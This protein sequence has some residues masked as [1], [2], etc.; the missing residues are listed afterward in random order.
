VTTPDTNAHATHWATFA[1]DD[2]KATPNLTI[3]VGLRWEYHPSFTD[4]FNN[5]AVFLPNTNTVVNGVNVHGSVV[6]PNGFVPY[7]NSV[8]ADSIAPTPI[9]TNT[10]AGLNSTLH[11]NDKTSFAPRVGFAWLPYGNSKTVIR[12][13]YGKYIE[14]I[15][16][17]LASAAW[18]VPAS[19]VGT[20]TNSVVNGVP[21]LSMPYP[22][23][24]N[25]AQ[26]GSQTFS[27]SAEVHYKDPYVQQWNFTIERDLGFNT[28]LRVTYDG[29]HG[30]NLG[31]S[32][33]LN[34]VMPNTVGYSVAKA[35]APYPLW[36]AV[37]EDLTGARSNYNAIT[38]AGNKRLSHGLQFTSSYTFAKNLSDQAGYNPTAFGTQAG[39]RASDTYDLNLDYGNVAFTRR[40]RFLATFL[41]EL[42]FGKKGMFLNK[43]NSLVDGVVGGWQLSGVLLFQSGPFLTIVAPG[44][45]PAGNN[46]QNLTGPMRADIVPGVPLY[47]TNQSVTQWINPAAFVTPANNIGRIGD[48]PVGA[49]VGP[50]T[51]AVSLSLFK[52]VP[53]K[54]NVRLQFGAA[55]ANAFNHPN[56]AVPGNLSV[57]TSGFGSITNVQTQEN[58]GPRSIMVTGRLSF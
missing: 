55:V 22:F 46:A 39:G 41:Y 52:T 50:G 51:Q 11:T 9:I 45:D 13:G 24:S 58:G 3:N 17:T 21:T 29:N 33:N 54:E 48:S 15:L 53:I 38:V 47:P 25:I 43:A 32:V 35:S 30:H 28:G 26:P 57:G 40:N 42:P 2:W 10:Q 36:A 44:A 27:S 16:G 19:D 56:Y 5:L 14:T 6:I 37:S 23:P 49:V 1:Q 34:Q 7:L 20:F 4:T 12:A 8:F 31:Y 18:G